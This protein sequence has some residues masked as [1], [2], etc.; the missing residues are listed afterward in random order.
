MHRQGED[1][2]SALGGVL[3][4]TKGLGKAVQY[5]DTIEVNEYICK[6]SFVKMSLISQFHK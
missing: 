1:W 2:A 6:V 4:A 5:N 3:F